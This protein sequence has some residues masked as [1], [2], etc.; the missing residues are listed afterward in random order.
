M[1]D[2]F[3]FTGFDERNVLTVAVTTILPWG[4]IQLGSLM[5]YFSGTPFSIRERSSSF[6]AA[7]Q[8]TFRT[9]FPTHRRNDQRN[10]SHLQIDVT[11]EKQF[12]IKKYNASAQFLVQNLLADDFLT[13]QNLVDGQLVAFRNF[14]R[15]YEV[16]F[17][18][19]F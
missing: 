14:G 2:E 4:D 16:R 18:V 6:D 17:K 7:K 19:N 13:T 1:A 10:D 15:Q 5:S 9:E 11:V 3:G 8:N 12:L